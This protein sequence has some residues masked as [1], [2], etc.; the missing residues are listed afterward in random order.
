MYSLDCDY[1]N[2][3]FNSI[4]DLVNDVI[5]SGMYPNYEITKDGKGTGEFVW[6]FIEN[7]IY[8]QILNYFYNE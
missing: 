3:S 7:N 4:E 5:L 8:Y 2:K 6:D 1:Y